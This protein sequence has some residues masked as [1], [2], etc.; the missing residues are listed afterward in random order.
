MYMSKNKF[1]KVITI[2]ALG[3]KRLL[4]PPW[5]VLQEHHWAHTIAVFF[6]FA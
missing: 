6:W 2:G 4:K 5:G 3:P 1:Q